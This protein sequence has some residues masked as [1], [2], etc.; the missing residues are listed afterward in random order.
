MPWKETSPMNERVEFVAAM[1][2]AEE[3]FVELCC[4]G[5]GLVN[6]Q[7]RVLRVTHVVGLIC[8]P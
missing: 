4:I 5:N 1:L 2:G 6:Q 8:Y 7:P 3:T